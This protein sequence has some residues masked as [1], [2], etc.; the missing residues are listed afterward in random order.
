MGNEIWKNMKNFEGL[1]EV[2]NNGKIR[3][4]RKKIL[5]TTLNH[6]GYVIVYLSKNSKKYAKKVHRLVAE[7][8]IPKIEGKKQVNHIDGN[9]QNNNVL[10]LEWCDASE[11]IKHAYKNKLY[12]KQR[13][14]AKRKLSEHST[15]RTVNQLDL[16]GNFIKKWDCI[17]E[18]GMFFG[19]EKPTAIVSCCKGRLHTAYGFK[20]EYGK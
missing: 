8:F 12:E 6:N 19:R 15:A 1:Y 10:N 5:K 9:K 3:N 13:N 16:E 2:S 18:A 14:M 20:W 17:K 7:T 11:N 4:S